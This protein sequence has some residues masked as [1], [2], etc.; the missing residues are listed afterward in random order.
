M[1]LTEPAQV[2]LR[3]RGLSDQRIARDQSDRI[4]LPCLCQCH[5]ESGLQGMVSSKSLRI[6][7]WWSKGQGGR[8]IEML[9]ESNDEMEVGVQFMLFRELPM[10]T[11]HSSR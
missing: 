2:Y 8:C 7:Y 11:G 4:H 1:R 9:K 6:L 3:D 10:Q 5:I